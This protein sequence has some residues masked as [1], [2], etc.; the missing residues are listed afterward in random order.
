MVLTLLCAFGA[1][2]MDIPET[3][4]EEFRLQQ[5]LLGERREIVT[6]DDVQ[7]VVPAAFGLLDRLRRLLREASARGVL[8]AGPA[9]ERVIIWAAA[10]NG[11][12]LLDNL[13]RIDPRLFDT[14]RHVRTLTD[15]LLKAWG[16]SPDAIARGEATVDA[17]IGTG[18]FV[19]T[20]PRW[21]ERT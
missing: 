6:M 20:V 10:L 8:D 7:K 3:Y 4:S 9:T 2:F 11:V 12:S 1:F 16:A 18:P 14:R 21:A 19:P 13:T 15:D 17:F 5:M